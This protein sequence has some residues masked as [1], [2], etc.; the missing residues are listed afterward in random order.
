MQGFIQISRYAGMREDLAQAGGGNSSVKLEDNTLRVKSSGVQLAEIN[1]DYGFVDVSMPGFLPISDGRPSIETALHALTPNKYTLHTHPTLVNMLLVNDEGTQRLS[2]LFPGC[3]VAGYAPPGK[4]LAKLVQDAK[5]DYAKPIFL[6]NHGLIICADTAEDVVKKTEYVVN[7]IA[8]YLNIDNSAYT[9][10]TE[11]SGKTD[12]AVVYYCRNALLENMAKRGEFR[13]DFCPDCV[14]Y[15]KDA[16]KLHNG[17]FYVM[18]DSIKKAKEIESVLV[19]AAE[20]AEYNRDNPI[21]YLPVEEQHSLV[22]RDDEKYR[23]SLT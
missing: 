15:L 12:K 2:K 6:K 1:E 3:A 19:F 21:D 8:R 20:V 5:P 9:A 23:K 14:V 4:K 16:I 17:H 11:L 10:A 13:F 22:G 18:A 7:R